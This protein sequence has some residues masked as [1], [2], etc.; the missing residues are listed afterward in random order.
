MGF[1]ADLT[2]QDDLK[3]LFEHI[4]ARESGLDF[5]IHAAG[6]LRQET[7]EVARIEDFDLQY[8]VNVR[9]PFMLTQHLLPLLTTAQ[10]Q[11]VFV[12]STVGLIAK[13][14]EVCQYSATKHA[15]RAVADS[16]REEVNPKGIR[17]L[18][19]Y[20]G[21]TATPLQEAIHRL[22]ARAYHPESLLQPDDVASVVLHTLLLPLT[23][24]VTD[25]TMR[26]MRKRL[27]Q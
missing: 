5:L 18:S 13:R 19:V 24:E 17:V 15:L 11:I 6:V 9:A 1:R 20:L 14:P 10:G 26:P 8:S 2:I 25:I 16:L 12:N 23:A 22:E 27:T 21:R 4:R 3:A 7:L